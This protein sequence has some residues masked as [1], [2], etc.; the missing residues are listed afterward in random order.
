MARSRQSTGATLQLHIFVYFG[1]EN[2]KILQMLY[3]FAKGLRLEYP[4]VEVE[5]KKTAL[6]N[7]Q[8]FPPVASTYKAIKAA[9]TALT[10]RVKVNAS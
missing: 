6:A 7:L 10:Y 9:R 3:T 4:Q 5:K 2:E 1:N 8:F